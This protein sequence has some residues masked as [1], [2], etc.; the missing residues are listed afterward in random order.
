[1]KHR[2]HQRTVPVARPPRWPLIF[3]TVLAGIGLVA[4]VMMSRPHPAWSEGA[5]IGCR[6]LPPFVL[7]QGYGP[8]AQLSTVDT[9]YV[10]LTLRNPSQPDQGVYQHPS[11]DDAGYLG[12]TVID[13]RGAIFTF[14][15]PHSSLEVNPPAQQ[16]RIYRVD[17]QSGVMTLFVEL[18]AARPATAPGA[19]PFG[20]LGLAYDCDTDSLY[21]TSVAGSTRSTELGRVFQINAANGKIASQL[22]GFDGFGLA[23]YNS[24]EKRLYVGSARAPEVRSLGLDDQ[25]QLVDRSWRQ[26][27]SMTR[28]TDRAR[29]LTFEVGVLLVR[30][31][32]FTYNLAA[33]SQR[34]EVVLPFRY[35]RTTDTWI[36]ADDPHVDHS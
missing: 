36:A 18:P 34:D 29:R 27:V 26:E 15:A 30:G 11:W 24:P 19:S 2:N 5:P 22:E 1:M 14:P 17:P 3:L 7:A 25:G 21:A 20:V 28:P 33:R 6:I 31:T 16:N 13:R 35:D 9:H 4:A 12:H 23:V 8:D 32:S 10:G